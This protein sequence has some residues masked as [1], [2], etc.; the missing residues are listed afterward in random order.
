MQPARIEVRSNIPRLVSGK[1]D[2]A[3]IKAE[4]V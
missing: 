1:Y 3:A 2:L 4:R